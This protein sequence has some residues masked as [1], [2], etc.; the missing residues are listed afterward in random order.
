MAR[1]SRLAKDLRIPRDLEVG[2]SKQGE[3]SPLRRTYETT[4]APWSSES[5]HPSRGG[6]GTK[7]LVDSGKYRER[8]QPLRRLGSG[9]H[10]VLGISGGGEHALRRHRSTD[11]D[12]GS[13][14]QGLPAHAA[15]HGNVTS[16]PLFPASQTIGLAPGTERYGTS[17]ARDG[18]EKNGRRHGSSLFNAACRK[19]TDRGNVDRGDS[20]ARKRIDGSQA[21]PRVGIVLQRSVVEI[22]AQRSSKAAHSGEPGDGRRSSSGR[23]LH[24]EVAISDGVERR[25]PSASS[26]RAMFQSD[27]PTPIGGAH[28]EEKSSGR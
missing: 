2:R 20:L 1:A 26:D 10:R 11:A 13:F 17:P 12:R 16:S 21:C 19:A 27:Q 6:G 23:E 15:R 22:A 9:R 5:R 14:T 28:A 4:Q 18:A 7:V 25:R 24:L 8:L 3:R